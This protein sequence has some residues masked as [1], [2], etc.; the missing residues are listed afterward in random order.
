MGISAAQLNAEVKVT[1]VKEAQSDLKGMGQTVDETQSGFKG[2]LG[3]ALSF[4]AG[5]L[6][7]N[8]VSAAAGFLK[9][10]IG[11][12][13]TETMQ[14]QQAMAQTNAVLKSTHDASGETADSIEALAN[15]YS[16]LTLFSDDTIQSG[17]NMLLT[18]TN[19]GK[20]VFPLA[21][22]TVLDMSQAL[23]QDTK[24]SAIQLGKA[25]NDPITGITALQRVGVTFTD[26]QK[27]LIKSLVDSGN[28]AGA[29]KVILQELQREFGGSAEAA[30]KTLP[31]Q[32][33]ILS[34]S[35]D[36]MKQQLGD[37]LMPILKGFVDWVQVNAMPAMDNFSS[38]FSG[39][40][41]PAL[42]SF[43]GF[44]SGSV[45]PAVQNI[46]TWIG[47]FTGT[48]DALRPILLG[49][50]AILVAAV[51][52]AVWSLAS[53]VIAATWPVLAIGAAVAAAVAIFEHFYNTNAG[54][55]T[56][57]D[58]LVNGLKQVWTQVQQNFLP[59]MQKIGDWIKTYVWPA[60]QQVG[61]FL[62]STFTPVWTQLQQVWTGQ[63]LPSLQQLWT[64]LQPLL[65]V[66]QGI[67]AFV[68]A[69]LVGVFVALMGILR[70][71][72]Q[73]IAGFISGVA[74]VIGGIVQMVTGYVQVF[75]GIVQLIKD[76]FTGN[77]KNIGNDI[78]NIF[79]GFMN[80]WGGMGKVIS[81]VFEA[82]FKGAIGYISGFAQGIFSTLGNIMG[83][84]Q[85]TKIQAEEQQ[86]QMKLNAINTAMSQA[87]EVLKHADLQ[88]Q[89]ILKELENTKDPA[90]RHQLEMQ[91]AAITSKEEEA[92]KVIEAEKRKKEEVLKHLAD[93][94]QQEEEANKNI[95][96]K[97]SDWFGQTRD[98][99]IQI[100]TQIRDQVMGKMTDLKNMIMGWFTS[101]AGF[102]SDK[103]TGIANSAT[104]I[105]SGVVGG[106]RAMA[107]GVIDAINNLINGFNNIAGSLHLPTIPLIPHFAMGTNY[108]PGGM[109]VVGEE[110]PEIMYV[111]RGAQIIPNS[112]AFGANSQA[113]SGGSPAQQQPVIVVLEVDGQRMTRG[114]MPHIAN[115]WRYRTGV[116]GM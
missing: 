97:A 2:M 105:V 10:Q 83:M 74:T 79:A 58:G 31:G 92:K 12:V 67:G 6:V 43:G 48:G 41:V 61:A 33:Q 78:K 45:V 99:A 55:K 53:G 65:P 47:N 66:L 13:W 37:A 88:R 94:K 115:E 17:E 114:L 96:Q 116:F 1:G 28:V 107:N 84:V 23:G 16:H 39:T 110:G 4:A 34:Q 108:A 51:V 89:G 77:F 26:S 56:F 102:W 101:F 50:A 19:I 106:V 38:W 85:K 11:S 40:A 32:L 44:I 113:F 68:G 95:F 60:L 109:A 24:S 29:Q 80:I 104:N 3:N 112:L 42:Q 81:G 15:Q 5:G 8:A 27:N 21:T 62:V 91:L 98:K 22:K 36:D 25:L 52:P 72:T 100:Y 18:F 30:G 64:A 20:N 73:G 82:V 93:L 35:F 70:G 87:S 7:M 90:K 103:W 71:L 46:V 9:D 111:P 69:T 14:A 49:L 63:I 57:I 75:S 86:T 54:F 59:T 76:I